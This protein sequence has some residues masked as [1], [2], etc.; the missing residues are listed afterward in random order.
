MSAT[1]GIGLQ[2]AEDI[3]VHA[4]AGRCAR[5]KERIW[6]TA[7]G[8][9]SFGSFHGNML[10]SA[11]GASIAAFHGDG[12]RVRRDIVGQDQHRRLAI[13]HEIARHREDE[14]GIGAVHLGEELVDRLHRDVGP[15][16][17]QR[18]APA[19]HI[20]LVE[21]VAHLR[22]RPAGLRQH[23]RDDPVGRALQQVPDEGAADA[24]AHHHELVDAQVIHQTELVVGVGVPGPVD[25]ERAGGLAAVGIAQVR[26]DA[27]V[28]S[29]ELLDR[30]EGTPRCRQEI[31]E[32][33]PPPGMSSRGKPEP[34]SS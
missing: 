25:L 22:T 8:I 17:D 20:G 10:T 13:A 9:R 3:A 28:L 27:A 19:L 2:A 21:Q 31:V 24:E 11:F 1:L 4:A 32:F 16:R 33:S 26:R 34:A 23:G 18:R 30:V 7:R 12:V 14:V 29:L 5:R 15:L 6:R